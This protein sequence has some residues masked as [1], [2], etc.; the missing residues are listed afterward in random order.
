MSEK[1]FKQRRTAKAEDIWGTIGRMFRYLK[2]YS[3][4]LIIV[5]IAISVASYTNVASSAFN[6]T[7]IDDYLTP[8]IGV[9]NPDLSGFIAFLF[10]MI[11][12]Y[13]I[14]VAAGFIQNKL[15]SLISTGVLSDIRYDLFDHMENMPIST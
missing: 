5:F 9:S 8:L 10:K 2:P 7:L 1:V 11:T 3:F 15:M 4:R 12:I 14:G 13:I 6:K